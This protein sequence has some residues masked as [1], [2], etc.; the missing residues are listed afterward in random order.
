MVEGWDYSEPSLDLSL[1]YES[2]LWVT[3]KGLPMVLLF[4]EIPTFSC[5]FP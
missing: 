2:T 4:G 5:I 1:R 3:M